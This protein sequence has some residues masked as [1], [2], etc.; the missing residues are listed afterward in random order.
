MIC[1]FE[2]DPFPDHG[3]HFLYLVNSALLQKR[4]MDR[5]RISDLLLLLGQ[6]ER[7]AYWKTYI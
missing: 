1:F 6:N 2:D 5:G 4:I 7:E 3:S